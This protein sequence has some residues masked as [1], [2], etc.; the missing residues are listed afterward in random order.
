MVITLRPARDRDTL[1]PRPGNAA[2]EANEPGVER[3]PVLKRSPADMDRLRPAL[4]QLVEGVEA[5][6]AAGKMHRDIKP[7]NVLVTETGRVVLLDFGV[8]TELAGHLEEVTGSGEMVGT[9]RYMAPEQACEGPPTPASDWYSVGVMLYEALVGHPPFAGTAVDVLTLKN[10]TDAPPPSLCVDDVPGDLD[11]LCRALLHRDP[12]MRPD[13][14]QI[15]QRLGASG[16]SAAT[17]APL[18]IDAAAA[19]IGRDGQLQVLREAFDATCSGQGI[20]VRVAGASGMGKSTIVHRF[21]DDLTKSG[22]AL[23]LR[24]RAY[25]RESVPYK[26]VDSVIDALSRQLMRF[27]DIDAPLPLPEGASASACSSPCSSASQV[28]SLAPRFRQ[29]THKACAGSPSEHCAAFSLRSRGVSRSSFSSMTFTG[30]TS[31]ARDCCS[32]FCGLRMPRRC[33][34]S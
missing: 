19:F 23:V 2:N 28:S 6:H 29:R 14:A 17:P 24:G 12:A 27:A 30:A 4:R 5:L 25:E 20:T 11:A 8:A 13:G 16:A 10:S 21:L 31:T 26:V 1:R 34:S 18:A 22:E 33:S 15:L 3:G 9:A 32:N 7:S